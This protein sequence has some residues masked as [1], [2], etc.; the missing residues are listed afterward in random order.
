M[1]SKLLSAEYDR[2][3]GTSEHTDAGVAPQQSV[4]G[5]LDGANGGSGSVSVSGNSGNGIV[6][7]SGISGSLPSSSNFIPSGSTT[8]T[9]AKSSAYLPPAGH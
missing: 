1:F 4:V 3:E 2:I 9:A 8:H 6:T 5:I 7:G